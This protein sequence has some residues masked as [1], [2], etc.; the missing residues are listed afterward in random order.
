MGDF[1]MGDFV[2]TSTL[3]CSKP[4]LLSYPSNV[5]YLSA[6]LMP[7]VCGA[8][9]LD[10]VFIV[11]VAA[12]EDNG[13]ALSIDGDLYGWGDGQNGQLCRPSS[14]SNVTVGLAN[15]P[16]KYAVAAARV[17]ARVPY[18]HVWSLIPRFAMPSLLPPPLSISHLP[19]S[20]LRIG[21]P[22][23]GKKLL[24]ARTMCCC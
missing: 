18:T 20:P 21:C 15:G 11:A 9:A 7:I 13:L 12:G 10:R 14:R 4:P 19:C 16:R 22:G 8:Q 3:T 2:P 5:L 6:C 1:V 17:W 23:F 24:Q